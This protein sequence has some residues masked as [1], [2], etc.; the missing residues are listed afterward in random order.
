MSR[1]DFSGYT[2]DKATE[3]ML[4]KSDNEKIQTIWDRYEEQSPQCG[5]GSLGVCCKICLQ[6]P[7]RIDPFDENLSEGTCG[8]DADTIVAR[9]L[10]R[11]IA[12][13]TASHSGH[14]KH[15]AHILLKS[16]KG[17]YKDY[18]IKDSEKLKNVASRLGIETGGKE[19]SEIAI[20]VGRAALGEFSEKEEAN[21]WAATT[22]TEGMA[23]KLTELGVV[24]EGIDSIV[25]E[26]MHRTH[27]GN[28]SEV[29]NL[30]MGGVKCALAD[31]AGCHMATDIS[32][33]LFGTPKPVKT[34]ANLGVLKESAVNIAVHGH[35]PALSD[36]MVQVASE[37]EDEAKSVGASEGINIVGICC[38]GN[39]V[40]M[41]HGIPSATHSVSQEMAIVT[42]ALEAV[43]T[44]Y[45]CVL[46]SLTK[47]ADCYH[48]KIITTMPTSK[49][50]GATHMEIDEENAKDCAKDII[51]ESIK[52]Y[53]NR[54]PEKTNIP[55]DKTT[56]YAGFSTEAIVDALSKVNSE[57]PLKPLIDN[58]AEGNIQGVCLFAGCNNVKIKQDENYITMAKELAKNNILVLATGCGGGAFA[59]HGLLTP[60]ATNE[61]AGE[62]LKNVLTAV[63][64]AAGLGGPLPLVLHVGSCV[65]NSRAV[66][67]A[68]ALAN[69]LGVDLN[70]LPVVASAPESTTEKA[71]SIGTWAVTGGLPTHVEV[72]PPILG[73]KEVVKLLTQTSKELFGG[74]FI[75]EPDPLK[76]SQLLY[77]EIKERRRGLNLE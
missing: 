29:S 75:A 33:I 64:E 9:N 24:P 18:P 12:A 74:Y 44:D 71:I 5:F 63:G 23:K 11:Q 67:I 36:I 59:R 70:Q 73:S 42:G 53:K 54:N 76:A 48:T 65:D 60:E 55:D 14:A 19:D 10:I 41:R 22:V 30:I 69:K 39:E 50:K 61:Y 3:K 17:E 26:I 32:D 72:V 21:L 66:D 57:D 31:Y 52:A 1:K 25:S 68:V 38:T 20:E 13:G 49:I 8:A 47:I 7:C 62:G 4:E 43:V 28:D 16:G 27:Y 37:L 15:L 51:K 56:A 34:E 35:N 77:D 40:L 46:P 2:K 45:Q 58:I 6:G